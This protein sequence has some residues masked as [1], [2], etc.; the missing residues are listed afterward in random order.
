MIN[1]SEQDKAKC[2]AQLHT[3]HQ[4]HQAYENITKISTEILNKVN[5]QLSSSVHSSIVTSIYYKSKDVFTPIITAISTP[6]N[7][8]PTPLFKT[9]YLGYYND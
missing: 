2:L 9:E 1:V 8:E 3:R 4:L 7:K 6:T 5:P